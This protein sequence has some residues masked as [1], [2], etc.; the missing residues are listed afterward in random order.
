MNENTALH[1]TSTTRSAVLRM[2]RASGDGRGLN[3]VLEEAVQAWLVKAACASP[4]AAQ[5]ATRGYQWKSL[6]L[7][8]GTCLRFSY[9][10]QTF[11]AHVQ[12]DEIVFQGTAY[13][14]RQWPL[15]VTGTVRN[16]W[17]ELWIRA[18]GDFR[19][20][21]ADTRRHIL[22]RTARGRLRRGVDATGLSADTLIAISEHAALAAAGKSVPPYFRFTE[23]AGRGA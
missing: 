23:S 13:S 4:P 10:R 19:W 3:A 22:R 16:A 12:G 17:R 6:F 11:H 1:I 7:P 5:A 2:L 8:E 21:L 15:H 9:R 20:H 18:P 14:P